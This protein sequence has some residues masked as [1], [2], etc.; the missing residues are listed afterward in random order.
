MNVINRTNRAVSSHLNRLFEALDNARYV[1][2]R[3]G[4]AVP[5]GRCYGLGDR[6]EGG[7]A[8]FLSGC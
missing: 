7:Q 1:R 3:L 6:S 4:V 8:P 2:V 5:S